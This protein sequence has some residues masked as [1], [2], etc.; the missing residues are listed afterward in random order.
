MTKCSVVGPWIS[1]FCCGML[2]LLNASHCYSVFFTSVLVHI[3]CSIKARYHCTSW[4]CA[5]RMIFISWFYFSLT[6]SVHCNNCVVGSKV[7]TDRGL[8][9]Y[10]EICI[11]WVYLLLNCGEWLWRYKH[12]LT[13]SVSLSLS[14]WHEVVSVVFIK[15]YSELKL[16]YLFLV[17]VQG[18]WK[19]IVFFCSEQCP[20]RVWFHCIITSA[21]RSNSKRTYQ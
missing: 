14:L 5:W 12:F 7:D 6:F 2:H 21:H 9:C 4:I 15:L 19:C 17:I 10:L 11:Y 3:V 18:F 13:I 8:V 20:S 16:V 1:S